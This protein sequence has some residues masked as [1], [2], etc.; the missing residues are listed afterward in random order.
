MSEPPTPPRSRWY[1]FS[2][3]TILVVIAI[4]AWGLATRPYLIEYEGA[5]AGPSSLLPFGPIYKVEH[6]INPRLFWPVG[7]LL[8]FVGCK[9]MLKLVVRKA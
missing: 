2:L 5:Y 8:G 7:V 9:C 6:R 1:Q 3:R 4:L